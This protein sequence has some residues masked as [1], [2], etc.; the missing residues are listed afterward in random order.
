MALVAI[1]IPTFE[2]DQELDETL[3]SFK[4]QTF[5][6]YQVYVADYD[7]DNCSKTRQVA[8]KHNAHVIN[9]KRK[10]IGYARH[11]ATM[12]SKEPIILAWDADARF[13]ER[14]ALERMVNYLMANGIDST[15]L[16]VYQEWRKGDFH[17]FDDQVTYFHLINLSR[18][19][20]P[21]TYTPGIM[22]SRNTYK[23]I[24]F[25]DLKKWE[26]ILFGLEAF[27]RGKRVMI[28]PN[29]T[30]EVSGRRAKHEAPLN[31]LFYDYDKAYR[32]GK[33][34]RVR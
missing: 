6:D 11:I 1:C 24:Q 10:G 16:H 21:L 14:D 31:A 17:I 4:L 18:Y 22:F 25:K 5:K 15:I 7:P 26:D 3:H 19:M 32:E 33:I 34:L 13:R 9:V 12:A 2:D 29:V 30:I 23:E 8:L 27:L 20:L 28:I